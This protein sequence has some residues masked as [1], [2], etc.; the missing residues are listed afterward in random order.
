MQG[1]DID[2][3]PSVPPPTVDEHADDV[4]DM[5]KVVR[6]A[7]VNQPLRHVLSIGGENYRRALCLHRV[8]GPQ[9]TLGLLAISRHSILFAPG[10][11][12]CREC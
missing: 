3:V 2:S 4:I 9:W 7:L 5:I 12:V 11:S 8:H 10:S 6:R 1:P